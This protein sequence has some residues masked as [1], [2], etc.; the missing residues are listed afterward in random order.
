MDTNQKEM[1]LT[2]SP[3]LE[4]GAYPDLDLGGASRML[5]HGYMDKR[6]KD[7]MR[8]RDRTYAEAR[9]AMAV[10]ANQFGSI[11]RDFDPLLT[12]FDKEVMLPSTT[13]LGIWKPT[14]YAIE[15]I[16]YMGKF[17]SFV[18]PQE[19]FA[20]A[21]REYTK[22][23]KAYNEEVSVS[24]PRGRNVGWPFPVGGL[25]R[26][27]SDFLLAMSAILTESFKEQGSS[28]EDM[29]TWLS[30]Y[31]GTPFTIYAERMQH[32]PKV[33]PVRLR[34]GWFNSTNFEPRTRAIYMDPKIM[35][36][37]MKRRVN[38]LL[39][40]ILTTDFHNPDKNGIKAFIKR[41]HD[42]GYHV[43]CE[44][45]SKFD[46]RHGGKRGEQLVACAAAVLNDPTYASDVKFNS[47]LALPIP[48]ETGLFVRN[49]GPILTSG[50]ADTT[51]RGCMGNTFG[52]TYAISRGF[53]LSYE[54]II[55]GFFR[56]FS[57][58][59]V[60]GRGYGD[61]GVLC[62]SKK[63][64][65]RDQVKRKLQQ[66][67]ADAELEI[68]FEPTTRFLGYH[69]DKGDF[70]GTMDVG[71]PVSRFI[72]QHFFP[73]RMKLFPFSTIGLIARLELVSQDKS[74]EIH[75]IL[76]DKYWDV[77]KLGPK[78]AYD[79]RLAYFESLGP[80]VEKLASKISQVDDIL[81]VFL[82]GMDESFDIEIPSEFKALLGLTNYKYSSVEELLSQVEVGKDL[83]P[84]LTRFSKEKLPSYGTIMM[85]SASILGLQYKPGD[86]IY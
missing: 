18:Y 63:F 66:G 13:A 6:F 77:E 22:Y 74:R 21:V 50:S 7:L 47:T 8:R 67:F 61:D 36:M 73:E 23:Y 38:K 16:G 79:D 15:E 62:I 33:L 40:A 82:H 26:Q 12:D 72:Q 43:L 78:F 54:E 55:G 20:V 1:S 56:S 57:S 14:H 24:L 9:D 80:E 4:Y 17:N 28:V 64:G 35:V 69:Y 60:T 48:T 49:D 11:L 81:Q 70:A 46:Q 83:L 44:D 76:T 2:I 29:F 31:H 84:I 32:T 41:A 75:R 65:T 51:L 10:F 52:S 39:R 45:F 85:Q 59:L 3:K 86:V 34:D 53:G 58:P 37:W 30:A 5:T 68:D 27:A 42:S 71:Y 25:N 19:L